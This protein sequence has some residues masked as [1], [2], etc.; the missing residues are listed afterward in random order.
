MSIEG[1]PSKYRNVD[2][3]NFL[4]GMVGLSLNCFIALIYPLS[5][6]DFRK[7]YYREKALVIKCGDSSRYDDLV[8]E[9]LYNLE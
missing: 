9:H 5:I 8:K 1:I 4:A 3:E 2:A 7:K 6:D